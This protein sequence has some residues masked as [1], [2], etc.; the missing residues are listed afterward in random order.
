MDKDFLKAMCIRAVRTMCQTAVASIGT[1]Q[2]ISDVN[3]LWVLSA[4][5]LSGVL[6]CMTSFITGLPEA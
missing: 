4:S 6:S 1:A 2:L 3:W 5:L